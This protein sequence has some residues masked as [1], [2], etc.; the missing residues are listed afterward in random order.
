MFESVEKAIEDIKAGKM[1]IVV[2]AESR[3]NEGDLIFAAS[4]ATPEKINFMLKEGRGLICVALEPERVDELNLPL[5]VQNNGERLQ[6][7]FTVSVEVKE[8]TTTG[9]SAK[10]R[11]LTAL[12]LANPEKKS[13]D[14]ISPGHVFP[15][16]ARKGGVLVRA[17]HTEAAVDLTRAA[18]LTGGGVICEIL[19]EDGSMARLPDLEKFAQKFDLTLISISDLIGY[20]RRSELLVKMVASPKLPTDYGEFQAF[21][22]KDLVHGQEHM[23]LVKGPI[24]S[25]KNILVRVHSECLT[26]DAFASK[27]CDCGVQLDLALKRISEEGG[28]LLYMRQEG[29]G[30]G[31]HN[32]MRAYELQDK[33]Y[34]TVEANHMLGFKS[35]ERTYGIGAQILYELGVRNIRLLTNNPKKG[36]GLD[37]HGLCIVE[38]L[39]IYGEPNDANRSYLTTKKLKMGHNLPNV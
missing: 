38:Q 31:L 9:I 15:L 33:G 30:I 36:L 18:G 7:A 25:E 24:D 22:F 27:R 39:P 20:R 12:A 6:T 26:G 4:A 8:G 11:C 1:V 5:M 14:F 10:D 2:D 17:G 21:A 16:K 29:R 19:N 34:D 23:A 13:K 37:G 3:E 28:V 32:K 35:D